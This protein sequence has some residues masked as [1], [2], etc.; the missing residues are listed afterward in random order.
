MSTWG[1]KSSVAV[2]QQFEIIIRGQSSVIF[3]IWTVKYV[4]TKCNSCHLA[5]LRPAPHF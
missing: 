2:M 3:I 4:K 5:Y 1:K